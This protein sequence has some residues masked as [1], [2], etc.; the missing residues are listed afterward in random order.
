M[1]ELLAMIAAAA[2][3]VWTPIAARS[4]AGGW[5]RA[6]HTGTPEAFRLRHRRQPT[7]PVRAGVAIGAGNILLVLLADADGARA[8]ARPAMGVP[9]LGVALAAVVGRRIAGGAPR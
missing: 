9:W 8:P 7:V 6:R 4:V 5:V 3:I 2:L 1:P